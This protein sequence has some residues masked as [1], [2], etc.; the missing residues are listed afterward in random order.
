[1]AQTLPVSSNPGLGCSYSLCVFHRYR[2][3][4]KRRGNVLCHGSGHSPSRISSPPFH[5]LQP[6]QH[7]LCLPPLSFY[8]LASLSQFK[9]I[10]PLLLF[11]LIPL[12]SSILAIPVFFSLARQLLPPRAAFFAGLFFVLLPRT[13]MWQIMGGGITRSLGLLF[14]LLSLHLFF[15]SQSSSLRHLF[16]SAIFLSLAILTHPEWAI[17]TVYSLA[18]LGSFSKLA[19]SLLI[20]LALTSPWWIT[21]FLRFGLA[22]FYWSS[23][24]DLFRT[25]FQ[26]PH[27]FTLRFTDEPFLTLAGVLSLFGLLYCLVH[28]N[29]RLP[30]WFAFPLVFLARSSP[31]LTSIPVSVLAGLFVAHSIY[32]WAAR[33]RRALVYFVLLISYLSLAT[34]ALKVLPNY[35]YFRVLSPFDRQA[36]SWVAQNTP[37]KD[38][39][40]LV[41]QRPAG[42]WGMDPAS[43]WF[44]A[45]ARRHSLATPQGSEW[46]TDNYFSRQTQFYA[47]LKDCYPIGLDCLETAAAKFGQSFSYIYVSQSPMPSRSLSALIE[48]Q[49]NSSIHYQLIY[50]NP[51]ALIYQKTP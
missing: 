36:M 29:W 2:L 39:F 38:S 31:N 32:P 51:G 21:T 11:S 37:A 4:Y 45:L 14:S 16:P 33:S 44:P 3:P 43:E 19:R 7:P 23:N 10:D 47:L 5:L 41:T 20:S 1:M 48:F 26:Y 22:P 35:Y 42:A 30:L 49:L 17:F 13:F 12:V 15:K 34:V 50:S 28:K 6:P 24:S 40:L 27:L 8:F 18:L 25:I 9:F 46:L